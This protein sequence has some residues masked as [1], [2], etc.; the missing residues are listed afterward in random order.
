MIMKCY[1]KCLLNKVNNFLPVGCVIR[2]I[3]ILLIFFDFTSG[4]YLNSTVSTS[5]FVDRCRRDCLIKRD[6][7]VCGKYRVARWL[8][9]VARKKVNVLF[10]YFCFYNLNEM[11]FFNG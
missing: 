9:E 11:Y 8:D 7:V 5:D 1:K 2:W 3:I 6:A 4:S 10:I